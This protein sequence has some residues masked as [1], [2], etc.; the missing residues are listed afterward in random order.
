MVAF[1]NQVARQQ[2]IP[3]PSALLLVTTTEPEPVTFTVKTNAFG[4]TTHTAR[5]G[6]STQV[7]FP[8]DSVTVRDGNDRSKYIRVQAEEG[9][10]ISVYGV[11]DEQRSTDGF[12]ALS[13]DGMEL[14]VPFRRYEYAI[15][16]GSIRVTPS[17]SQ[18]FSE[19]LIIPCEDDTEIDIVPSQVITILSADFGTM[20]F[21]HGINPDSAKWESSSGDRPQ[22]G[23]TLLIANT[24]DL[25][26]SIVRSDKPVVVMSGH[27]CAQVPVGYTACDHLVEQI[28][29]STTWGYTFLVNPLAARESGDIYRIVTVND[30]TGVSVTCADEGTGGNLETEDLGVLNRA[31]GENWIE[32]ATTPPN[33]A[34]CVQDFVRRY[35]SIQSTK[36]VIV[37]QYSQGYTVDMH[38]TTDEYTELGDPFMSLIPPVIQYVNNYTIM[39]VSALAGDF[40]VRFVSISVYK[41]FFQPNQIMMD[42]VAFEPAGSQWNEIHCAD[43]DVCGYGLYREFGLGDHVIYHTNEN[44]GLSVQTYGFQQQNSYGLPGGMEMEPLSGI[45]LYTP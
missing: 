14:G 15:V 20:R 39:P 2:G 41:E 26:G 36:P 13:C 28:P 17:T 29:P 33:V 8:A 40:P 25:T 34:P 7:E 44:A 35:C 23:D 30:D 18:T 16:S 37:A 31:Q 21:G 24:N 42:G 12:V 4:T 32:Y 19:F 45:C 22:A 38:C 1:M 5:Y 27:Q 6:A 9:K 11:S 10:T 3:E 43:G